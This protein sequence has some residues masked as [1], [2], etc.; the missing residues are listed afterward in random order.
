L[1]PE[2][3]DAILRGQDAEPTS[4]STAEARERGSRSRNTSEAL[5]LT[6]AEDGA[7]FDRDQLPSTGL[8]FISIRERV[9]RVGGD[10]EIAS[11]PRRGVTVTVRV[12][13]DAT[14]CAQSNRRR[15]P[16]PFHAAIDARRSVSRRDRGRFAGRP[17]STIFTVASHY[18][19]SSWSEN[20]GTMTTVIGDY[21]AQK[22]P[23]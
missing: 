6:I 8:G 7:G 21:P 19:R 9:R 2:L 17:V 12:P 22:W 4:P 18:S 14:A 23:S 10:V 5:H 16:A 3:S 11:A 15:R 20:E 13:L 1:A